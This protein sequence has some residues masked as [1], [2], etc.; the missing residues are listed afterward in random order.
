MFLHQTLDQPY[1]QVGTPLSR[2]NATPSDMIRLNSPFSTHNIHSKDQLRNRANLVNNNQQL[3]QKTIKLTLPS[4]IKPKQ[5]RLLRQDDPLITYSPINQLR[6]PPTNLF[7]KYLDGEISTQDLV[8]QSISENRLLNHKDKSKAQENKMKKIKNAKLNILQ[9]F[10]QDKIKK[11]NSK[12]IIDIDFNLSKTNIEVPQTNDTGIKSSN[13]VKKLKQLQI[14]FFPK[15]E[16]QKSEEPVFN[17]KQV[18]N[19]ESDQLLQDITEERNRVNQENFHQVGKELIIKLQ[20]R[21]NQNLPLYIPMEKEVIISKDVQLYK[22]LH[23]HSKKVKISNCKKTETE[24]VV[25]M[26]YKG[27]QRKLATKNC[28]K[29]QKTLYDNPYQIDEPYSQESSLESEQLSYN[30]S[31]LRI[32]DSKFYD[33]SNI[34]SQTPQRRDNLALRQFN[35]LQPI[36]KTQSKFKFQKK[37]QNQTEFKD[38]LN[39]Q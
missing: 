31:Y 32:Q 33:Q 1:S 22:Y 14:L 11:N 4:R 39:E 21:K 34:N 27:T 36:N 8:S 30:L 7:I 17:Y 35:Y 37:F 12:G 10:L 18:F 6:K 13:S 23:D 38:L 9:R 5:K 15:V 3:Q 29:N 28:L 2:R 16:L 26:R 25:F 20:S 24:K 19:V